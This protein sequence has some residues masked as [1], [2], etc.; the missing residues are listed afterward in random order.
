MITNN[1][2]NYLSMFLISKNMG[3]HDTSRYMSIGKLGTRATVSVVG[4]KGL[5]D[6]DLCYK[7]IVTVAL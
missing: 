3:M 2:S 1:N 7:A 5:L 6:S 4:K